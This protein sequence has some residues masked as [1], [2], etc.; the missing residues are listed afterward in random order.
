MS[1]FNRISAKLSKT[2][3]HLDGENSGIALIELKDGSKYSITLPNISIDGI[4]I[5]NRVMNY[6]GFMIVKT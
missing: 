1:G 3:N 6:R 5:G 2:L 4:L